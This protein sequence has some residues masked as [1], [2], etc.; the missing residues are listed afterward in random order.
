MRATVVVV[1]IGVLVAG[2]G[3][4]DAAA[5]DPAVTVAV[6]PAQPQ[7]GQEVTVS[8]DVTGADGQP[9]SGAAL[10]ATRD[11]SAGSHPVMVDM[12]D[13]SGHYSFTDTPGV[14]GQVT[15]TVTWHGSSDVS[16]HQAVTVTRKPT[17]LSLAI[18]DDRLPTG[19]TVHL[20]AHL[21]S[22]TTDR[23]LSIYAVPY[24]QSRELV[25]RGDVDANGDLQASYDVSRRTK[26]VARFKGDDTWAPARARQ[27]VH[28]RARVAD[29]LHG[30][31]DTSGG[32][33]IYHV[34]SDA[35][36][37]AHLRPE[38]ADVCLYFRAQRRYGGAWHTTAV[39]PCIRTGDQ[40]RESSELK[41]D[42]VRVDEPYR[43]R[44]EWRGNRA[45]LAD[46][47]PWRKLRFRG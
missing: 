8:G 4:V 34:G 14:Y 40:G 44:A 25:E 1:A 43:V 20:T 24:G 19:H 22:P 15:W 5:A 21:G 36:V 41:G 11:D 9:V 17:S 46:D 28:V 10:T 18:S 35:T 45:A 7:V 13:G 26:F 32:Y 31:Y 39:S 3:S 30:Y 2:L 42:Y 47:G 38:L 16:G 23:T 29:R 12:A 37:S 33:R 6:A 27:I